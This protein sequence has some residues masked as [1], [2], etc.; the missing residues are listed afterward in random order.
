M[1]LCVANARR[2]RG[3]QFN[4]VFYKEKKS[5]IIGKYDNLLTLSVCLLASAFPCAVYINPEAGSAFF[6]LAVSMIPFIV[7]MAFAEKQYS[8]EID[9]IGFIVILGFFSKE[10][11][12]LMNF[13]SFTSEGLI[14]QVTEDFFTI[15]FLF[16]IYY[17]LRSIEYDNGQIMKFH[18]SMVV[19]AFAFSVYNLFI[20]FDQLSYLQSFSARYLIKFSSFFVNVNNFGLLLYVSLMAGT[21]LLMNLYSKEQKSKVKVRILTI[22]LFFIFINLILTFSRTTILSTLVFF[23][24][25]AILRRRNIQGLY[26]VAAIAVFLI[27]IMQIE[28]VSDF[29]N[30]YI[31]KTDQGLSNRDRVWAFGFELIKERPLFGYGFNHGG[32]LL[33][34]YMGFSGYHN[35]FIQALIS[36]GVFW[37]VIFVSFIIFS[38]I[39]G[40]Q[41]YK[42]NTVNGSLAIASILSFL[43]YGMFEG[44]ELF[45]FGLFGMML[46]TYVIIMPIIFLKYKQGEEIYAKK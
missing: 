46:T 34:E 22:T 45:K 2:G 30:Q 31:F 29:V 32:A 14:L 21:Y 27:G 8:G 17:G 40:I 9:L 1:K 4:N 26:A 38:I 42:I 18:L 3:M 13:N 25:F 19:I 37:L 6:N 5:N 12:F 39:N 33:Q 11:T 15:G 35:I 44:E 16:F 23:I 43:V 24:V 36:G 41:V 10:L 20:N 28:V 7:F